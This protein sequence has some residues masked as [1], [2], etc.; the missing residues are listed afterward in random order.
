MLQQKT[1]DTLKEIATLISHMDDY[2]LLREKI[3][4]LSP[5]LIP[6]PEAYYGDLE[7]QNKYGDLVVDKNDEKWVN[8]EKMVA[9]SF[10]IKEI[11]NYQKSRYHFET[12]KEIQ[13]HILACPKLSAQ[14]MKEASSRL[15]N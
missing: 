14:A 2:K 4:S 13:D 1:I 15:E 5:P 10:V 9:V 11:L 7:S 8:A 3:N 12:V 6:Y